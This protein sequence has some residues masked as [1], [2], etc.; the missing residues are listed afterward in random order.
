MGFSLSWIAVRGM[1][2]E[3]A[4]EALGMEVS[5]EPADILEGVAMLEWPGDWLVVLSGD[6]RD[7]LGGDLAALGQL[8]RTYVAYGMDTDVPYASA[9][10]RQGKSDW[11]L[12]VKPNQGRMSVVVE[13]PAQL[14]AIIAAA[15]AQQADTEI[16]LFFE[17]PAELAE[18][19]CG[20]RIGKGD[21]DTFGHVTLKPNGLPRSPSGPGP[22]RAGFLGRLFGRG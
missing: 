22:R 8:G 19:I 4:L 17:I 5:E 7:A 1:T 11:T 18:S 15:K 10:G 14:D 9:C 6:D 13:V 12:T 3:Q 21:P 16:D 20:F 2:R